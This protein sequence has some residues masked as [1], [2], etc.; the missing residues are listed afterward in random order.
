M[1][2]KLDIR[3]ARSLAMPLSFREKSLWLTFIGLTV[4]Y[5]A[6]FAAV[7]PGAAAQVDVRPS[8]LATLSL[9]MV[10]LVIV[11]IAGHVLFALVDRRTGV[12]ERDRLIALRGARNGGFVL[13]CAVAFALATALLRAGNF[14]F[15]HVLLA[16][17]VVSQLVATGTEIVLQ[18]RGA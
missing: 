8:Q 14:A 13:S 9:A 10:A 1:S 16:G 18:R 2:K 6:Y 12:D 4:T 3:S 7:L 17:W 11:Q 5:V 15:V